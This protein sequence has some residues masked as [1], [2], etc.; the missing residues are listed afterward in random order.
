MGF[1]SIE[2]VAPEQLEVVL[3]HGLATAMFGTMDLWSGF[4]ADELAAENERIVRGNIELIA[5]HQSKDTVVFL[6]TGTMNGLGAQECHKR[7]VDRIGGLAQFA[8]AHDVVLGLEPLTDRYAMKGDRLL[9]VKDFYGTTIDRCLRIV[10]EIGSPKLGLVFDA[11]QVGTQEGDV[12][13]N[14]RRA[15]KH[16]VHFQIG[17]IPERRQPDASQEM[18][19]APVL[20]AL[21]ETGYSGFVAHEYYPD[22]S[23]RDVLHQM[24]Q[25]VDLGWQS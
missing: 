17:G 15:A 7:C 13:A 11:Y 12:I 9:G 24:K 8:E 3:K 21:R 6:A 4:I 14:I 25:A 10:N 23:P 19:L 5:K 18:N 22:G 16:I 2:A 1:D 20:K